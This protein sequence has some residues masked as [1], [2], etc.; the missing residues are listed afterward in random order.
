MNKRALLILAI[1]FNITLA[2]FCKP[3]KVAFTYNVD[4]VTLIY[5]DLIYKEC[6]KKLAVDF[7]MGGYVIAFR[8]G[9]ES[10]MIKIGKDNMFTSYNIK[11]QPLENKFTGNNVEV[12]LKQASFINYVTNFTKEEVTEIINAKMNQCNISAYT[13]NSVFKNAKV[14]ARK[15]SIGA[16]VLKSNNKNGSYTA[17]YYLLS[18]Q[19]IKWY[20]LDNTTN[21]ILLELTT[22]GLYMAYFRATKGMVASERLKEITILSIEE[23]AQKFVN[24][25]EFSSLVNGVLSEK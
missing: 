21:N 16:E 3:V 7:D 13:Q 2:G 5:N 10:Q 23:A 11:L 19:K 9:Y 22:D 14:D 6:P 15:F 25:P 1:L 24:S 8:P 12:E 17:P 4:Y 20:V 18:Q